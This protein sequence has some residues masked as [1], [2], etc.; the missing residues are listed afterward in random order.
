MITDYLKSAPDK[1]DP[2]NDRPYIKYIR[3]A[4]ARSE[5]PGESNGLARPG[6]RRGIN[7][8]G[9]GGKSG[10][11]TTES[12]DRKNRKSQGRDCKR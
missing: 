1:C 5:L 6:P 3:Q 2:A 9:G 8:K 10:Y 11:P 7:T 12:C 4:G